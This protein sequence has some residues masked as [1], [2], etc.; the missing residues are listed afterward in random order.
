MARKRSAQTRLVTYG[1]DTLRSSY[2]NIATAY[3]LEWLIDQD[4]PNVLLDSESASPDS[5]WWS[6]CGATDELGERVGIGVD[7]LLQQPVEE[8]PARL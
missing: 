3:P 1:N 8:H 4:S 5:I 7:A 2:G 6:G